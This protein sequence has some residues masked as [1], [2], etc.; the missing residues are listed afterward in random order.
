MVPPVTGS[1][2]GVD[3][4]TGMGLIHPSMGTEA[5]VTACREASGMK[6]GE[7]LPLPVSGIIC[8]QCEFGMGWIENPGRHPWALGRPWD[9][10]GDATP[11][12]GLGPCA[13]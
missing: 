2:E 10:G 5:V 3:A 7:G 4:L 8:P 11:A 12:W 13:C 1:C 6:W 9:V